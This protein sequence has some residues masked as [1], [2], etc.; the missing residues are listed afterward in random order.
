MATSCFLVLFDL[1]FL[2]YYGKSMID[3]NCSFSTRFGWVKFYPT[4]QNND[5]YGKAIAEPKL[6]ALIGAKNG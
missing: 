4:N 5:K 3:Q 2:I 6:T 1:V